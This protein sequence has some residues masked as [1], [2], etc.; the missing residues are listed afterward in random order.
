MLKSKNKK[1]AVYSL[2]ILAGFNF[3]LCSYSKCLEMRKMG[4][5]LKGNFTNSLKLQKSN[6][7]KK[8]EDIS[9]NG[10]WAEDKAT[11]KVETKVKINTENFKS[12]NKFLLTHITKFKQNLPA[13]L[14]EKNS[15]LP[16]S[17]QTF[18]NQCDE[19]HLNEFHDVCN[20]L[21]KVNPTIVNEEN[22]LALAKVSAKLKNDNISIKNALN[23]DGGKWI[24]EILLKPHFA[25][26]DKAFA[27]E[28][29]CTAPNGRY[30]LK[31]QNLLF[32]TSQNGD[33][34]SLLNENVLFEPEAVGLFTNDT[35]FLNNYKST[36]LDSH[37]QPIELKVTGYENKEKIANYKLDNVAEK[38][39]IE[40]KQVVNKGF[41]D[42]LIIKN[43]S[44]EDKNFKLDLSSQ[45]MDMFEVR[46]GVPKHKREYK[47]T[48]QP[49][50][51]IL[52]HT[53]MDENKDLGVKI[54]VSIDG[55]SLAANATK[56]NKL[57]IQDNNA[58][59]ANIKLPANSTRRVE[60]DIQP[61][62]SLKDAS[63]SQAGQVLAKT[64]RQLINKPFVNGVAVDES[65]VSKTI[66]NV[67]SATSLADSET[68][69]NEPKFEVKGSGVFAK[70]ATAI[71][72]KALSDIELL[73]NKIT[74]NG[75]EYDSLSAGEPLFDCTFGRD[76]ATSLNF[77]APVKPALVESAVELLGSLQGLS[78][79]DRIKEEQKLNPNL[80]RERI[81][82]LYKNRNEGEGK[83]LHELRVGDLAEKREID[84]CPHYGTVDATPLWLMSI[85]EYY[86]WSGNKEKVQQW[87]PQMEKSLGWI[88]KNLDN[89]GFLKFIDPSGNLTNQGWKDSGNSAKHAIGADGKIKLPKYPIAL[90]EVQGYVYA[91]KLGAAAIYKDLGQVDKAAKYEQEAAKLKEN[92]NNKFWLKDEKFI[93]MALDADG[94]AIHSYT[95]DPITG[96]EEF[97]VTSNGSQALATGIIDSTKN[98]NVNEKMMSKAELVEQMTMSPELNNGW[99]IKTLNKSA[100][101]HNPKDYHNGT[102]WP[103]DTAFITRGLNHKNAAQISKGLTEAVAT[104]PDKRVPEVLAGFERKPEDTKVDVYPN[105]C[106]PQLWSSA[107]VVNL[108]F[109]YLG[110]KP[111]VK[112]N[113]VILDN[114]VLPDGLNSIKIDNIYFKGEPINLEVVRTE[115]NEL[116]IVASNKKGEKYQVAKDKDEN[117]YKI[118]LAAPS[119]VANSK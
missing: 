105:A 10:G 77:L 111:D 82:K 72:N 59:T 113:K 99:G 103:H 16:E 22:M 55:K 110:I 88:N 8:N 78:L 20:L 51:S 86:K 118:A 6:E 35:Q 67:L 41:F 102:V 91:A 107:G 87:L 18:A 117:I 75:K 37:D 101:A 12:Y 98:I 9:F 81:E 79:E 94:N 40:R 24:Q 104:F 66:D 31:N 2:L 46:N 54:T 80:S 70:D 60:V 33:I 89:D 84:H 5:N 85:S 39:N 92:F 1:I 71:Y 108:P 95:K 7:K 74:V 115:N 34:N 52:L 97:S 56:D 32:N 44:T 109:S 38:I 30:V 62:I 42:E 47:H 23:V 29:S 61:I 83:I 114:P 100:P 90:A 45:V 4:I 26:D 48:V 14:R 27:L 21:Q 96:K 112:N 43:N 73:R 69:K 58:L 36:V 119:V 57:S 25:V 19:K 28:G 63:K 15:K 116:S 3:N 53:K 11:P 17:V 65:K 50:G 68:I 106:I 13:S 76:T 93:A 64:T 49:D